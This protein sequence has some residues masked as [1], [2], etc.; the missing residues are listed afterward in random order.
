MKKLLLL[1][2]LLLPAMAYSQKKKLV[3]SDEF[4]Y[5][6]HPDP[7]KWRYE[8]GFVRHRESQYYTKNRLENAK[9]VNGNLVITAIK[10]NPNILIRDK[11]KGGEFKFVTSNSGGNYTSASLN[12]EDK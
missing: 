6:G 11:K 9:V 8:E 4:N 3:W 2:V 7:K 5:A 10:E 1:I 12:T